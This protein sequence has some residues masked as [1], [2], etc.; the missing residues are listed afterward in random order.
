MVDDYRRRIAEYVAIRPAEIFRTSG[1]SASSGWAGAL[2]SAFNMEGSFN[3]L[4]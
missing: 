1:G 3:D 2:T 4:S